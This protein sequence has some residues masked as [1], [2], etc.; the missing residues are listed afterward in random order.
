V[1]SLV[2]TLQAQ[3]PGPGRDERVQI[4]NASDEYVYKI[5]SVALFG[6][7]LTD[8]DRLGDVDLAIEL[9]PTA[10]DGRAFQDQCQSR[11]HLAMEKG[12]RFGST[13]DWAVWPTMEIF[14]S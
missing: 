8:H 2:P 6:S 4:V 5:E 11:R 12:R 7:M 1:R 3:L 9:L 13:F 10:L 14:C